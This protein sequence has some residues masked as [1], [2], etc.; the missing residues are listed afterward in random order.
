MLR[1]LILA[2]ALAAGLASPAAAQVADVVASCATAGVTSGT[3][4]GGRLVRDQAGNLCTSAA[5]SPSTSA[6]SAIAP[7]S[8]GTQTA[9][10]AKNSGANLY[11]FSA[12][13]GA[14]AGFLAL[15]NTATAPAASAAITPLECVAV[16]ANGY[17]A[18]RQDIADRYSAGL[19][20]V[21]SSSCT[22]YAAVAPLVTTVL[23]Q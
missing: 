15:L 13:M 7:T 6:G 9:Y 23:V 5:A 21:V 14:T 1:R 11:G 19:T 4:P 20:V 16:P 17:V 22:T 12:T 18:R 8:G 10:V 2:A 3:G